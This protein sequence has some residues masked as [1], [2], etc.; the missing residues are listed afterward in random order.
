MFCVKSEPDKR[1]TKIQK[2]QFI[3]NMLEKVF[4]LVL[5]IFYV[6]LSILIGIGLIIVQIVSIIDQSALNFIGTG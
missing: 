4:P 2:K 1:L 5:T 6:I 3:E